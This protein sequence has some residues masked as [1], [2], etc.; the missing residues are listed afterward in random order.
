MQDITRASTRDSK[1]SLG[2]PS[3]V[4]KPRLDDAR[5]AAHPKEAELGD[6]TA[7]GWKAEELD[8]VGF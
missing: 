7:K 8:A 3:R 5:F 2:N 6:K 4:L 1:R